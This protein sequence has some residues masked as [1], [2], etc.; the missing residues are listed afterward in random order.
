MSYPTLLILFSRTIYPSTSLFLAPGLPPRL[1]TMARMGIIMAQV[2]QK[3]T[4]ILDSPSNPIYRPLYVLGPRDR[5]R[6]Q[7][8]PSR[9][10]T[11][12]TATLI[13]STA[14]ENSRRRQGLIRV[15]RPFHPRLPHKPLRY[16]TCL[17]LPCPPT[18]CIHLTQSP[19]DPTAPIPSTETIVQV[20]TCCRLFLTKPTSPVN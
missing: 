4:S 6:R 12:K 9:L 7:A 8:S 10:C 1:L 5:L 11:R 14:G 16:P 13:P 18:T 2:Q 17:S 19:V 3:I 15:D 20:L